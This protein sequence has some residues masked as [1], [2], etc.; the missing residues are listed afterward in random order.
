MNWY[1]L[2]GLGLIVAGAGFT[3]L[4]W[5]LLNST[6]LTALGIA[7]I[8]L[9]VVSLV[10]G[11]ARPAMPSEAGALLLEAGLEN[12]GALIEELG[13][14]SKAIYLPSRLV[15]GASLAL[16]PMHSNPALPQLSQ[17][18]PRRLIVRHGSGSEDLGLL[19][20]TPGTPAVNMLETKPTPEGLESALKSVLVGMT[21]L[22]D[23]VRIIA[24]DEK[25]FTVKIVHPRIEY[26]HIW[27][28]DYL[29]SPLASMVASITA[30]AL[31]KAVAIESELYRKGKGTIELEVLD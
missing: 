23:D 17:P 31:D 6:P 21:D 22:V 26:R 29:G 7:F 14:R 30:E 2:L 24:T 12:I 4:S 18:L 10:L 28:Y 15:G 13:L 25:K 11:R 16:I 20:A 19:V 8:I 9:G 3:P 1:I 5:L 27:F